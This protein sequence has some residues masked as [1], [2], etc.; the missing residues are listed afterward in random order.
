MKLIN[1]SNWKQEIAKLKALRI[2]AQHTISQQLALYG[3]G[4]AAEELERERYVGRLQNSV[5]QLDKA[6]ETIENV[7]VHK[8][9]YINL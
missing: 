9:C 4:K 7:F 3:T 1:E 6:I 5:A 8:Q 2:H